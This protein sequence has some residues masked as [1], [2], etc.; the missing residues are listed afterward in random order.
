ME[1]FFA[2]HAHHGM[3]DHE[4][5]LM[6]KQWEEDTLHKHSV[7]A[8]YLGFLIHTFFDGAAIAARLLVSPLG[9]IFFFILG[10]VLFYLTSILL[11][12]LG[13]KA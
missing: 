7:L 8:A 9:G 6:G 12:N 13:F 1:N 4:H 10:V 5:T 2:V 3:G 11:E